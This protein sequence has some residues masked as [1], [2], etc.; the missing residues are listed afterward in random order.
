[1]INHNKA[2]G[3]PP[4]SAHKEDK[5]DKQIRQLINPSDFKYVTQL[6]WKVSISFELRILFLE[7]EE[8][9]K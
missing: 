8:D 4:I 6:S 7:T 1:M 9:R 3:P 2:L 5:R